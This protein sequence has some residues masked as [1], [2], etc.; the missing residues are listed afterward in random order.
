[1]D[2]NTHARDAQLRAIAVYEKRPDRARDVNRGV[3][4]VGEGLACVYEQGDQRVAIDMPP[5]IGGSGEGPTPGFYGRAAIC[6]CVAIGIK[7]T[8]AREGV[9]VDSVRVEIEQDWDNRGVLG[10]EGASPV[11]LDTRLGIEIASPASEADLNA[12]VSRALAVDPWF[13]S[14]LEAQ[15]VTTTVSVSGEVA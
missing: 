7:M 6:G 11:A 1:M 8:A 5:T 15:P 9:Q 2:R 14:F 13:L 3:A 10:I 12:L 4:V